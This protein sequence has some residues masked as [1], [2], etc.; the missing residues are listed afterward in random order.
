MLVSWIRFCHILSTQGSSKGQ[1]KLLTP[2]KS[3][4]GPSYSCWSLLPKGSLC[5]PRVPGPDLSYSEANERL[6]CQIRG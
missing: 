5:V 3:L 1:H 6:F 4:F 2:P